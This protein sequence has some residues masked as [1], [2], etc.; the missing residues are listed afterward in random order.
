MK[1]FTFLKKI[2]LLPNIEVVA[3]LSMLLIILQTSWYTST[4]CQVWNFDGLVLEI[5]YEWRIP[6]S[7]GVFEPRTS[8]IQC[9]YLTH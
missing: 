2:S 5:Y 9:S 7:V 6:V 3:C 1:K 8:H 4:C